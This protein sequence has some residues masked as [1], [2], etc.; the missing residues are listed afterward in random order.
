MTDLGTKHLP[1]KQK[2]GVV[3]KDPQVTGAGW[4]MLKERL[5]EATD[6]PLSLEHHKRGQGN[7]MFWLHQAPLA[8]GASGAQTEPCM[9]KTDTPVQEKGCGPDWLQLSCP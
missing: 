7:S 1:N 8:K 6:S 9:I 2:K 3:L 4:Q 5:L